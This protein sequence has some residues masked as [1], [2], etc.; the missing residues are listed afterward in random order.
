MQSILSSVKVS[1]S[2]VEYADLVVEHLNHNP[3]RSIWLWFIPTIVLLVLNPLSILFACWTSYLIH[4][5]PNITKITDLWRTQKWTCANKTS[6][7]YQLSN[8]RLPF[9]NLAVYLLIQYC[10]AYTG[11]SIHGLFKQ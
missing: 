8:T 6:N 10:R 2:E 11:L 3:Y 1:L 5:P 9:Y 4:F 7:G